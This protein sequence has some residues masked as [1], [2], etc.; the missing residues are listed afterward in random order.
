MTS[1]DLTQQAARKS[2]IA[3]DETL[4]W[5]F[6]EQWALHSFPPSAPLNALRSN[7]SI[8]HHPELAALIDVPQDP[9]WHPEGDV[10]IHTLHVCDQAAMIA[11]RD[12]LDAGESIILL[13]SSLCH[14]LGKPDTTEF[15]D[16]HWRA[17]GHPQTGVPVSQRFLSRIGC[18]AELIQIILPLVAEHLVHANPATHRRAVKKL[19]RRLKPATVPQ[20]AR[21]IEADLKGRPPLPGHMPESVTRLLDRAL[22][23]EGEPEP[24]TESEE[25]PLIL[26]RHLIALGLSPSP[27]FTP[28]LAD[29]FEA[30]KTGNF[31]NEQGGLAFLKK[32]LNRQER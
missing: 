23:L 13:L 2:H 1:E 18:P 17:T 14:D 7:G 24:I 11:R 19:L 15:R 27:E 28:L 29:C 26:G 25:L 4:Q 32:L 21:L 22:G 16:G 3:S 30:Q 31:D 10:W 20:L 12:H 5:L 9:E 8:S 6:W